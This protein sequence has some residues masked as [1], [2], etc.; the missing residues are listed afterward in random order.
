LVGG[1]LLPHS[2]SNMD[3]GRHLENRYDVITRRFDLDEIWY[4]DTESHANDDENVKVKTGSRISIW[5]PFAFRNRK[6]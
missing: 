6:W 5:R 2:K 4:A 1:L 3:D